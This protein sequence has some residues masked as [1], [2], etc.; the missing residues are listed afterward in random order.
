MFINP[1]GLIKLAPTPRS[2]GKSDDKLISSP[3]SLALLILINEHWLPKSTAVLPQIFI[4]N[5]YLSRDVSAIPSLDTCFSTL[6][7]FVFRSYYHQTYL[8]HSNGS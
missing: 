6:S 5:T 8:L 3:S 1:T 7:F 2:T 4:S